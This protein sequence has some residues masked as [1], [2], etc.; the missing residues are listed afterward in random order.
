M[1]RIALIGVGVVTTALTGWLV[2]RQFFS[3]TEDTPPVIIQMPQVFR[4][5][6]RRK[7]GEHGEISPTFDNGEGAVDPVA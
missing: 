6:S 7:K 1:L 2:K 4:P 3:A 5:E